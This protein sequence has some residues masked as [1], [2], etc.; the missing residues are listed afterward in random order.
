MK[1]LFKSL[2]FTFL[3]FFILVNL[4][5]F[6][7]ALSLPLLMLDTRKLLD[8]I[9][10]GFALIFILLDSIGIVQMFRRVQVLDFREISK[11][12]LK[13]GIVVFIVQLVYIFVLRSIILHF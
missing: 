9:I 8:I 1:N 13:F 2:V 7:F 11:H 5:F 4:Y 6:V 3:L 10:V 12:Q